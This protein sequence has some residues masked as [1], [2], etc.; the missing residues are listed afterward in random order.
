MEK[1]AARA[2]TS[3]S[4]LY[5]RWPGRAQL[6]VAA[7]G[8]YAIAGADLPDTG[9]LRADMIGLLRLMSDRMASPVG[10]ML[11]GLVADMVRDPDLARAV[12]EQ[13]VAA[14][15]TAVMTILDRAV[16]R[17]EVAPRMLRS[18]RATV[19]TD[20]LRN[21][22]LLN[23]APVPEETIIDIVDEVYLPLLLG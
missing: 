18:R 20:L 15:P 9:E 23:G 1:V 7:C 3:K 8:R 5:R 21:E 14:G 22:F 2:R 19:A 6:V 12:R 11:R 4:A 16:A 13:V 10:L 17:G